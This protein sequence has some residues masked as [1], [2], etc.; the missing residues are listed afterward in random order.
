MLS[1]SATLAEQGITG[2]AQLSYLYVPVQVP[3]AWRFLMELDEEMPLDGLTE[4]QG[5]GSLHQLQHLPNDLRK[6]TFH[7]K[8]NGSSWALPRKMVLFLID[9][10]WNRIL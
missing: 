2:T 7:P 10:V 5:I 8:F 3:N 9:R 6:L 4:L 1:L